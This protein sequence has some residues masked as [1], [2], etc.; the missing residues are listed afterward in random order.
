MGD[1]IDISKP[2]PKI[3][4]IFAGYIE[5]KSFE[6]LELDT[7]GYFCNN[8]TY[9]IKDKKECAIVSNSGPDVNEAKSGIIA[10]Y[11]SCDLWVRN[12]NVK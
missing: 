3:K 9:F 12:E 11:G 7:G 8:C 6:M 2:Y 1:N 10:P 5:E 4:K